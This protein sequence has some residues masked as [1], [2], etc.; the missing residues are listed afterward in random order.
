MSE[1]TCL[2]K[3]T[4]SKKDY[5]QLELPEVALA[6]RSNVGKSSLINALVSRRNLAYI[7]GRPGKTRTINFYKIEDKFILV[8][9]PGYGYA[10]VSKGERMKW[11]QMIDEYLNNRDNLRGIVQILDIRHEP[12]ELDQKMFNWIKTVGIPFLLVATKCDKISKGKWQHHS[13]RIIN[14]LDKSI[15]WDKLV[16]FSAVKGTGRNEVWGFLTNVTS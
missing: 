1:N 8:D 13:M 14:S 16:P 3:M 10:R 11:G 4:T 12:T 2:L 9:L 5:P 6:G 7:S 15:E